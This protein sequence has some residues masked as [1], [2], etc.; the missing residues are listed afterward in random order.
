MPNV[1]IV[2]PIYNTGIYVGECIES[3]KAQTYAD[4]EVICVD[5]GST[6]DSIAI[7]R[8]AAGGDAR[9]AFV[10]RPNGG[11]SAA[12]NTGIDAATGNFIA[13][14]DSD[15]KYVPDALERLVGA[16][17]DN[18]ADLVDFAAVTFYESEEARELHEEDNG[19][20]D[21]VDGVLSGPDLF[22]CYVERGQYLSSACYHLIKRDVLERDGLRFGDG[23]LHEDELFTPVLYACARRAVFLREALYLRR[24]HPGSIMTT[25]RGVRNVHSVFR[26]TQLLRAWLYENAERHDVR[27]VDAFASNI[28]VLGDA[29][30]RFLGGLPEGEAD[31]YVESLGVMDRVDFDLT[32]RFAQAPADCRF[33]EVAD[34]RSYRAAR[35]L[36]RLLGR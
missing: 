11:L 8:E 33:H 28:A 24:V 23:L 16:A 32:C 12:R 4:F 29:A 2:V 27:F 22:C 5:D 1:S 21:A 9:F 18:D 3:L 7:A 25:P 15:D 30:F 31:A 20:R 17:R 19:L 26:I 13:F 10:Q 34:S 35:R 14:L 6:D 36:A